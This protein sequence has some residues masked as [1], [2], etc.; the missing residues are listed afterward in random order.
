MKNDTH[1]KDE[2]LVVL[3]HLSDA[4]NEFVKLAVQ[5]PSD[6]QEFAFHLHKIQ[7]LMGM[8]V[9]RR[10]DPDFWY[11]EDAVRDELEG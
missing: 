4:W 8:R 10:L 3:N 5:H 6:Q 11:I 9:A 7:H 2:E 1:L